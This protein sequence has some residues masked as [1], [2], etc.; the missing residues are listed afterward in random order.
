M[1]KKTRIAIAVVVL[2]TG[3][4]F[5]SVRAVHRHEYPFGMYHRCDKQLWFALREYAEAHGGKF[6]SGEATPE[7]SLSLLGR[8]FAYLLP[9][10]DVPAR[11]VEQMLDRGQLLGPETCGWNYVE[12]LRL[13]SNPDLALFWDKEGLSEIGG[14]L[15]EGG[16]FVSFLRGP[17]EYV[18]AARWESFFEEQRKLR[19]EEKKRTK[20]QNVRQR[21]GPP[22]ANQ[23]QE[24][25]RGATR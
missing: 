20:T 1:T 7:A 4:L 10:R 11:V 5:I 6:P 24:P 25:R 3:F 21:H 13:D 12:G 14:R 2:V 18:P 8:Q 16:H 15:P 23:V 19:A 9:R 22:S 17:Y